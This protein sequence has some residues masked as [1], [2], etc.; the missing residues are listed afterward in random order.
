MQALSEAEVKDLRKRKLVVQ[1][2]HTVYHVT[3]GPKFAMTR[4]KAE[5]DLTQ[6]M[7]QRCFDPAAPLSLPVNAVR[8]SVRLGCPVQSS[9]FGAALLFQPS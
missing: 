7:L 8:P 5:T 2:N 4:R 1:T 3:K 9:A 6:D